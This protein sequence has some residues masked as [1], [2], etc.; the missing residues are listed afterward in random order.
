MDGPWITIIYK[1]T[2]DTVYKAEL[3]PNNDNNGKNGWNKKAA[4]ARFDE[5]MGVFDE[6]RYICGKMVSSKGPAAAFNV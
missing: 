3:F 4:R 6:V 1:M 5:L 2:A